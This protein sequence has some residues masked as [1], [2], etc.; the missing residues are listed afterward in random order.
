MNHRGFIH[1]QGILGD[2]ESNSSHSSSSY[3]DDS[4]EAWLP[5]MRKRII[6]EEEQYNKIKKRKLHILNWQIPAQTQMLR[7]PIDQ[8]QVANYINK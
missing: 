5:G 4:F 2:N 3:K 8:Q 6:T 7:V 1:K